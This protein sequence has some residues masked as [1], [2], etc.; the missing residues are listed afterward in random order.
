MAQLSVTIPDGELA[1]VIDG[2][3]GSTG[4]KAESG[5]T[6]QQWAKRAV[7]N[8]IKKVVVNQERA[9]AAQQVQVTEPDVT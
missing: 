4:W 1:R 2:I 7:A 8:W 9:V 6:K 5:L 3:C